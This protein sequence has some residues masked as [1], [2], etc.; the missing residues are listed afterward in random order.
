MRVKEVADLVGI[1][2]R[3]LHHYDEIGLLTPDEITDSGYRLY[4]DANLGMLQQI[5]FFRELGLPLRRIKELINDPSFDRQ[6]TLEL[7]RKM[8]LEKRGRLDKMI[9][10]IDKTIRHTKGEIEMSNKEKF[11]G[12]DFSHNPYEQEARER[13]GDQAV[14]KSN[15]K[16]GSM[17]KEEQA[18]MSQEIGAIYQKIAAVRNGSPESEEAQAAIGE[19][20]TLL[21]RMGVYSLEAFKGLGQLYVDDERFTKNI[22]KYGDGLAKYMRDAMAVYAD[23]N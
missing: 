3:T 13:W 15:A 17:S 20:Y 12:F 23:K 9:E 10:T 2:V 21:N 5:L 7:H 22:D 18:A 11:E 16:L 14:D 1:S 6:E 19:W 8:L 4:S